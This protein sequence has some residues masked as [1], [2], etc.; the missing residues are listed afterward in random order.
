[1]QVMTNDV[2]L[3]YPATAVTTRLLDAADGRID[4]SVYNIPPASSMPK[5]IRSYDSRQSSYCRSRAL[6]PWAVENRAVFVV[7]A[8][9]KGFFW[10]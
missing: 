6:P 1:M 5:I 3:S 7:S 4:G 2:I 9:K 10:F 8:M